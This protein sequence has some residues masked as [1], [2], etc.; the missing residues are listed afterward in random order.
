MIS[1]W[2]CFSRWPGT[3]NIDVDRSNSVATYHV[4]SGCS[5]KSRQAAIQEQVSVH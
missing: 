2:G 3:L 5:G 1:F 4:S